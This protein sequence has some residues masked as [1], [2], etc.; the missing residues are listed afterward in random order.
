LKKPLIGLN[1]YLFHYRNSLWNATKETYYDAVWK[2]GGLPVTIHHSLASVSINA[3]A[4]TLDG[5]IM[6]GGP[7]VPCNL[8]EGTYPE[9]LD[10][11]VMLP[12]RESFDRAV[13]LA[14]KKLRKPILSICV[15][16]QHINVIYGGSLYEDIDVL[17]QTPLDHGEFNG[18]V[19][20]HPVN[21]EKNSFIYSVIKKESINVASTHHQGINT[22]GEGLSVSSIAPDG[23]IEAIEDTKNPDSFIA[24]QWHPEIMKDD[25][26]QLKLFKWVCRSK[27]GNGV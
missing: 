8:Y 1:P 19:S 18:S 3:I 23:L 4:D 14:M 16:T 13:F 2:A 26:N 5:L 20:F 21:I 12:A 22:L 6:V 24:V 15:G 7:D 25:E 17:M 10:K 11:D 9:L 27:V